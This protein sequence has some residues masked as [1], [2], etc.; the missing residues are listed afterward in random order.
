MPRRRLLC[1]LG[2]C[3]AAPALGVCAAAAA[4]TCALAAERPARRLY[5]RCTSQVGAELPLNCVA[6]LIFGCAVYWLV[7]LNDAPGRFFQFL[8]ILL[9]TGSVVL[10]A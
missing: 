9:E 5:F 7:G 6:P 10:Q 1:S 4:E 8:V 3:A 2:A